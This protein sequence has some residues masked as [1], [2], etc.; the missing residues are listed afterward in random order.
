V[1]AGRPRLV[2]GHVLEAELGRGGMGVVWRARAPDGRLVALKIVLAGDPDALMRAAREQRLQGALGKVEGF[3]E[4][5]GAGVD[6]SRPWLALEL[7]EG[8]T[9]RERLKRGPLPQEDALDLAQALA[10][11]MATAHARGIIHRDLKPENIL[12]DREGRPFISDLGLA[13]HYRRDLPGASASRAMTSEGTGIG[14]PGYFPLEQAMDATRAGPAADV[15]ALGAIP[16]RPSP[17]SAPS[18]RRR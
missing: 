15:F 13:K 16:T 11:A 5:L 2:A 14:T 8:G 12:F 3:V 4:L 9:L 10:R 7:L 17:A 1:D 18:R 6:G